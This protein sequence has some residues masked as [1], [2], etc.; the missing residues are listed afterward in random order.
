MLSGI[1]RGAWAA[2]LSVLS[3]SPKNATVHAPVVTPITVHFDRPVLP[4]SV[5]SDSFWA[6]ARTSGT[7]S[8][9]FV[10]SDGN[11]TVSLVP[12]APFFW[13]E[14]V[15]VLLSHDLV[16]ADG[17]PMRSA[18]YAFRFTTRV[19]ASPLSLAIV[20]TLSTNIAHES[21]VPYGGNPADLN[22]DGF[23]DV[24]LANEGT[25]DIRVFPNAANGTVAL[26]P[27]VEPTAHCGDTPSPSDF[28]DFDHDGN[29]DI[30]VGHYGDG[31]I[32]VLLGQGDGTFGPV[33]SI[34]T[35]ASTTVGVAALDVD[36]DG[37]FDVAAANPFAG[38]VSLSINQGNGVFGRVTNFDGGGVTE[39]P[40][41]CGDMNNDGIFDLV[42]GAQSSATIIVRL[43]L[44]NGSFAAPIVK[45]AAGAP[46]MLSVGDVN[47][48]GFEDVAV[49]NGATPNGAILLG[50][51]NGTLGTAVPYPVDPQVV[52]TDLMDLDGDGDL[53]WGLSSFGGDWRIL[54]NGGNGTFT[55]LL[56]FDSPLAASCILPTDLDNDG[57]IDL[58]LVDENADIIKLVSNSGTART[59]DINLD[60]SVDA[61][62]LAILLGQWSSL[63]T[64]LSAD[65]NG[66]GSVG[67]VDL[68]ILLG[69]WGD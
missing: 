54:R 36:G 44:G 34:S 59:G 25:D 60:G 1:T 63:G 7:V 35:T 17:S 29:T 32:G 43:G 39:W 30:V 13:G 19:R 55:T 40:L 68:G 50:N 27:I 18:G 46:W 33:Q 42:I 61:A 8:G 28:A 3:V 4:A 12:D 24:V 20:N 66:D 15:T 26:G 2:E 52:A 10:F 23:A 58:V 67:G 48:D 49:A 64:L 65:L 14:P 6:F 69:A 38:N 37:D 16:A 31:T 45:A 57:D 53:D 5:T 47:G 56:E 11:A 62:D 21:S 51:G 9:N 41:T 22:H